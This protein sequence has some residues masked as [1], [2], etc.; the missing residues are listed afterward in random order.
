[1]G[2]Q[3]VELVSGIY[4]AKHCDKKKIKLK[5]DSDSWVAHSCNGFSG[6]LKSH[7]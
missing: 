7:I 5:T 3:I 4:S 6:F 1:M 2:L